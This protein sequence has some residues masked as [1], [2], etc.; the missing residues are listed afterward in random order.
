MPP[1][2]IVLKSSSSGESLGKEREN[3]SSGDISLTSG[4]ESVDISLDSSDTELAPTKLTARQRAKLVPNT[5]DI[6]ESEQ[7]SSVTVEDQLR[8]SEKSRRRMLQRDEKLEQSKVE[9]IRRLLEKQGNR[10]KRMKNSNNPN[11]NG[12]AES[13]ETQLKPH[14]QPVL[15]GPDHLIYISRQDGPILLVSEVHP[16]GRN[17]VPK[18]DVKCVNCGNIKKYTHSKLNEPICS[19]T[20]YRKLSMAK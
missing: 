6:D 13:G 11:A 5:D 9:T 10:S 3:S 14:H 16:L 18:S 2:R 4:N 12:N 15:L 1:K 19:L 17:Y 8:K 7:V 20:C